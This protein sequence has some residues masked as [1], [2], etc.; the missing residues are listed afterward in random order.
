MPFNFI[1]VF[2]LKVFQKL[3]CLLL[4][5]KNLR[6]ICF[7]VIMHIRQKMIL[8]MYIYMGEVGSKL[9]IETKRVYHIKMLI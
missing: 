3:Q 9:K 6:N 1:L 5:P 2:T 4:I 7:V 8:N